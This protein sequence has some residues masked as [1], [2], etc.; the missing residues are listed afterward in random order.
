[1]K[2]AC[3]YAIRSVRACIATGETLDHGNTTCPDTMGRPGRESSPAVSRIGAGFSSFA[4]RLMPG[5]REP[6][7][8]HLEF[9]VRRSQRHPAAWISSTP[10]QA[11]AVAMVIGAFFSDGGPQRNSYVLDHR[12]KSRGR[13]AVFMVRTRK[14]L[15]CVTASPSGIVQLSVSANIGRRVDAGRIPATAR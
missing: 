6:C 7:D 4:G 3:H 13:M 14:I 10:S 5:T 8:T 2:S 11:V 1:M 15:F 9:L 12:F